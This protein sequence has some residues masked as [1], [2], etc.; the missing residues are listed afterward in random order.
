M[1]WCDRCS[2]Y[3]TP[4]SVPPEGTCPNCGAPLAPPA[5]R[6]AGGGDATPA[7]P[8]WHFWLLVAGV[9]AYLGWRAVQGI[10]WVVQHL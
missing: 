8:P 6:P 10:A 1:P 4:P 3:Y 7:R 2:R 5:G 9:V